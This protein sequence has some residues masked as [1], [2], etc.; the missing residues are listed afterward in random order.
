MI[1]TF[2][3]RPDRVGFQLN[4]IDDNRFEKLDSPQ[5]LIA[6]NN[7]IGRPKYVTAQWTFTAATYEYFRAFYRATR[8]GTNPFFIEIYNEDSYPGEDKAYFVPGTLKVQ[9]VSGHKFNVQVDLTVYHEAIL[10]N[11]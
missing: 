1:H 10:E 9:S 8:N 6:G 3:I 5:S 11:Q 7:T 2:A 4:Q